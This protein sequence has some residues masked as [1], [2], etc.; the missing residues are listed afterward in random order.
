MNRESSTNLVDV[1]VLRNLAPA[2]IDD[3]ERQDAQPLESCLVLYG[4]YPQRT[5][6]A[7]D[8]R[9]LLCHFRAPDAESLRTVLRAARVEYDAV[10]AANVKDPPGAADSTNPYTLASTLVQ[11]TES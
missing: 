1:F 5:W 9:R 6:L 4:I 10:W 11:Q 8:G 2:E 7:S 3:Q